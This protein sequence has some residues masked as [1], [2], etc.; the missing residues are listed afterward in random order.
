MKQNSTA[1]NI[2]TILLTYLIKKIGYKIVGF[3]YDIFSEG[4]WN[5]KFLIDVTAWVV[6]YA[7]VS[8]L[9]KKLSPNK[10]S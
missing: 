6:I 5:T 2:T 8:F 4:L 3:D 1:F 9:L 7:I 10:I